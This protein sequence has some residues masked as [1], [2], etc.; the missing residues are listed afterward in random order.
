MG[1]GAL[2]DGTVEIAEHVLDLPARCGTPRGIGGL[3]GE[4]ASPTCATAAGLLLYGYRK[5]NGDGVY[6]DPVMEESRVGRLRGMVRRI[7]R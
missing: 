5:Q 6:T 4:I 2:M 7:F 3:S 1:G